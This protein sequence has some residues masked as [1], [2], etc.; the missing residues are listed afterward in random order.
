MYFGLR[1]VA[2]KAGSNLN[3]VHSDYLGTPRV[4]TSGTNGINYY[5]QGYSFGKGFI[6]GA[7]IGAAAYTEPAIALTAVGRGVLKYVSADVMAGAFGGA[8]TQ[9]INRM[10]GINLLNTDNST[11]DCIL[12]PFMAAGI[13]GSLGGIFGRLSEGIGL[14]T[15]NFVLR[16]N[17]E[18]YKVAIANAYTTSYTNLLNAYTNVAGVLH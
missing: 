9:F 12:E 18:I 4:I 6:I 15:T 3:I 13:G 14:S 16:Q 17:I 2:V 8:G 5:S 1:P 10:N 11:R 7:T